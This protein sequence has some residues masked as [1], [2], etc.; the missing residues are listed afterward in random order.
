MALRN[1]P[2]GIKGLDVAYEQVI[3]RIDG[4]EEGF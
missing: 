1:L 2:K 4:Q 3:E